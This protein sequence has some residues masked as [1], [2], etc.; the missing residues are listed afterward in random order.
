MEMR[1]GKLL[2]ISKE[3][4]TWECRKG[5]RYL[6]RGGINAFGIGVM[7]FGQDFFFLVNEGK[8]HLSELHSKHG[9]GWQD[10]MIRFF[11]IQS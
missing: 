7:R 9:A 2:W 6:V 3:K 10:E 1:K 5:N 4:G 11:R 8:V